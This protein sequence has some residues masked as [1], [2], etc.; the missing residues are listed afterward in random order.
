MP[1]NIRD[2][3][4]NHLAVALARRLGLTKTDAVRVALENELRRL[5][6]A[7]PLKDRLH[8]IQ[9]RIQERPA[10][11]QEADKRF[12]DDLNEPS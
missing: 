9:D 11:G 10:T 8:S 5:D 7:V 12:Y 2:E 3:Q 1:L 4:V 6:R